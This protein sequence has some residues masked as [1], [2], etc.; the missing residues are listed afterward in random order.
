MPGNTNMPKIRA[1]RAKIT[2]TPAT[3]ATASPA[4]LL[5]Q[6]PAT[7]AKKRGGNTTWSDAEISSLVEQLMEAK[8]E[9]LMSEGGFKSIVWQGIANS[10]SDSKK[11]TP[12]TCETKWSRIKKWYVEV[13]FLRELSGFG[14]D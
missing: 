12:R 2:K 1:P 13:K 11:N 14:W 9:G 6:T 7:G 8:A 4:P 3:S 10:Y 5:A